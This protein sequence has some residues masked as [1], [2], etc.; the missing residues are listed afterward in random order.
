MESP[1]NS[2][3]ELPYSSFNLPRMSKA[4]PKEDPDPVVYRLE[5]IRAELKLS[6]TEFARKGGLYFRGYTKIKERGAKTAQVDSVLKLCLGLGLNPNWVLLGKGPR[7]MED[8][9]K[10]APAIAEADP[11]LSSM[12]QWDSC[13]TIAKA[14]APEVPVVYFEAAGEAR[15]L[16]TKQLTPGLLVDLAKVVMK[17]QNVPNLAKWL[18]ERRLAG[19]H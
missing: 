11:K 1:E 12:P 9:E 15:A 17:H 13:L 18:E 10:E 5:L 19:D 14:L 2:A 3:L 16:L 6:E 4:P 8:L 7:Y